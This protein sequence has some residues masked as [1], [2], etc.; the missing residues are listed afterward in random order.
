MY[1]FIYINDTSTEALMKTA[2]L[3]T[4]RDRFGY[5]SIPENEFDDLYDSILSQIDDILGFDY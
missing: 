5:E 1:K 4:L 3:E 2:V